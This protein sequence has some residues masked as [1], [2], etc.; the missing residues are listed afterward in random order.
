MG[1]SEIFLVTGGTGFIGSHIVNKLI[2]RN[3]NV[4]IVAKSDKY[5]WRLENKEDV[6][7]AYMDITKYNDLK[8]YVMKIDPDYII[9]LAA[10]V[11]NK[12]SLEVFDKNLEVNLI[13]TY[14]LL[15]ALNNIDYKLFINT[16]SSEEY[17]IGEAPFLEEKNENP[18]SPYSFSK[19]CATKLC[20]MFYNMYNKP[21][22]TVRPFLVYGPKQISNMLIPEL[23]R[24]GINKM[25]LKLTKGEQTRDFVYVE[26]L[27]YA[28]LTILDHYSEIDRFEIFNVG[29]GYQVLIKD[30]VHIIADYFPNNKFRLGSMSYRKNEPKNF[31]SNIKKIEK[32]GWSPE[33]SIE[34]GISKTVMWWKNHYREIFKK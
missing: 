5:N 30:I 2:K 8:K 1:K 25:E 23:I 28:Y 6:D 27:V 11:N 29:L 7:I 12:R 10:F 20:N 34:T 33:I 3:K 16:G 15:R 13:G 26:D 9:H 31:F 19:T 4:K 17:G 18:I 21:I 14:N 22:V 32:L 24:H